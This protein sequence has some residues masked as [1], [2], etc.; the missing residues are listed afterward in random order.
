MTDCLQHK[1]ESCQE[2]VTFKY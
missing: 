2:T 1:A